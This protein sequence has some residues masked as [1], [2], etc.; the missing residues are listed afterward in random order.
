[1]VASHL[2]F[3]HIVDIVKGYEEL[4]DLA[5]YKLLLLL[6]LLLILLL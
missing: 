6:L 3:N 2:F 5:L 1:M 4:V